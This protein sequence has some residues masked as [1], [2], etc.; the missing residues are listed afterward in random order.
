MKNSYR[1][2]PGRTRVILEVM[3][4]FFISL[5]LH[6]YMQLAKFRENTGKIHASHYPYSYGQRKNEQTTE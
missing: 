1:S 3:V 5:R 2:E 6:G 4:T